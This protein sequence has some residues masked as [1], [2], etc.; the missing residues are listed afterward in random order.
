[1]LIHNLGSEKNS[2]EQMKHA[3]LNAYGRTVEDVKLVF[4]NTSISDT[5]T[6]VQ[7]HDGITRLFDERVEKECVPLTYE[8]LCDQ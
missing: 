3:L 4:C 5:E 6:A 2:Y 8:A 7:A 1:M